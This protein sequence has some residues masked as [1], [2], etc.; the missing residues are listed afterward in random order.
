M[1]AMMKAAVVREFGRALSIEDVPIPEPGPGQIQIKLAA[2]GVCHTDLHAAE[3]DWPVKPRPPFIPGHEGVGVVSALGAGVRSVKL[4]DRVGV[5]WL[6]TSCG[7]CD[8]C[9]SAWE[10]LCQKQLN[11]GYSVNGSFA[12]YCLADPDYVGHFPD[13][14]DF[15]R[16]RSRALCWS[17]CL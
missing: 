7:H 4:G 6:H 2:T 5:P 17:D 3:G 9:L 15:C 8:H 12:E 10:T 14:L 11:T 16:C 1:V 13:G